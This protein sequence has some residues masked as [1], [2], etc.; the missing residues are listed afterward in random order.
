[1]RIFVAL[2]ALALWASP[3]QA[4]QCQPVETMM[5]TI[6]QIVPVAR[7]AKLD[8]IQTKAAADWFN[9]QPPEADDPYDLV[10]I[11]MHED[12]RVGIVLGNDGLA[13]QGHLIPP[14]LVPGL[15]RAIAGDGA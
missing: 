7:Y 6:H 13:C 15:M 10:V 12:G 11:V 5:A 14:Q 8:P 4:Q 3:A 2:L 1:M 9:R